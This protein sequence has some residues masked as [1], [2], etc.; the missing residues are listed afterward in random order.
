LKASPERAP[1]R[2][3]DR[4]SGEIRE[5]RVFGGGS[6]HWLYGT[7][8][9]RAL[10]DRVLVRPA[11]NAAYGL[12][13]RGPWTRRKIRTFVD[14]LGIDPTEAELPLDAYTSLAAFFARRLRPG[15]RPIDPTPEHLIAPCDGR[16]LA[17][18]GGA[19]AILPIKGQRVSLLA[20]SGDAR[21]AEAFRGGDALV[22]RLAPADYHRFHFPESGVASEP[23]S[24]GKLLHSV[25]PIALAGGA[26]S[27]SNRRTITT[28]TTARFGDLLLIE[29][30]A[31]LVGR[32]VQTYRPGRVTRGEEKGTFEFGGST[33]VVVAKA[34]AI[35]IDDDL[36]DATREGLETFVKMGTRV[37]TAAS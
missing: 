14:T 17:F 30:G 31:L 11:L 27:F 22:Y 34:G 8:P 35:A 26:P 20:L 15:T 29:I 10:T 21:R 3:R 5:E 33:V 7:R 12:W 9:G 36:V 28:L 16:L 37:A 2:F 4:E 23:L 1:T 18:R 19:D 25:H 13:Q 32:I 24:A 6:L